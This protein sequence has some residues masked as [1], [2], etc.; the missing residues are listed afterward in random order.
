[1]STWDIPL[2]WWVYI[3][4]NVLEA[5]KYSYSSEDKCSSSEKLPVIVLYRGRTSGEDGYFDSFITKLLLPIWRP[6]NEPIV[7]F[8]KLCPFW[9]SR[10]IETDYKWPIIVVCESRKLVAVSPLRKRKYVDRL[11]Q[12]G[13]GRKHG[14]VKHLGRVGINLLR[15]CDA[16]MRR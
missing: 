1:M 9:G 3:V 16:Y 14:R 13:W 15:P 12:N 6:T 4:M 11:V 2:N 10:P 5:I 8:L 7:H